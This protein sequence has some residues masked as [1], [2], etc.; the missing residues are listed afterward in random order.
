MNKFISINNEKSEI[1]Y[2]GIYGLLDEILRRIE[3]VKLIDSSIVDKYTD[4]YIKLYRELKG[5]KDEK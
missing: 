5:D 2:L 4:I 1:K 3:E